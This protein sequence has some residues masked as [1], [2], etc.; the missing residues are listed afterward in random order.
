MPELK[1]QQT[2][3]MYAQGGETV[4]TVAEALEVMVKS[5]IPTAF[6]VK[7]EEYMIIRETVMVIHGTN[8]TVANAQGGE[9]KHSAGFSEQLWEVTRMGTGAVHRFVPE[10][11][12]ADNNVF[13]PTQEDAEHAE[14]TSKACDSVHAIYG[15]SGGRS[16]KKSRTE[17]NTELTQWVDYAIKVALVTY[18]EQLLVSTILPGERIGGENKPVIEQT[19]KERW[20]LFMELCDLLLV[21][22][23]DTDISADVGLQVEEHEPMTRSQVHRAM[24]YQYRLQVELTKDRET[25]RDFMATS[26]REKFTLILL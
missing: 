22:R 6:G 18:E 23:D 10:D 11:G 9:W 12:N 1:Q 26:E 17:G 15:M 3:L 16:N 25:I 8:S 14:A 13:T 7:T 4:M 5:G 20:D 24:H 19:S 21:H 2:L